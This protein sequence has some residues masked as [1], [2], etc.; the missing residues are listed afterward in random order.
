MQISI[1]FLSK[2]IIDFLSK[3]LFQKKIL[4]KTPQVGVKIN[5]PSRA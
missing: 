3:Y 4:S 2:V 1:R 5:Q